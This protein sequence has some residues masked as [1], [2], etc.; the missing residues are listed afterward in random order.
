MYM[1]TYTYNG[2]KYKLVVADDQIAVRTRNAR[3]LSNAVQSEDGKKVLQNFK[4]T[5]RFEDSDVSVLKLKSSVKEKQ[6]KRDAARTTLKSEPELRFAGRVLLDEKGGEPVLY[7]ENL[8]IKFKPALTQ[9]Q[10][11]QIISAHQLKIKRKLPYAP[12]TYFVSTPEG[13]GLDVF[14]LAETMANLNEVEFCH[15]ELI[16]KKATKTIHP[17]QWHLRKTQI[18]GKLIDAHA[19]VEAAHTITR[20]EGIVIAVIDDGVDIDHPEFNIPGKVIAGRDVTLGINNPRPKWAS[21]NHGTSCA[22]VACASGIKV[23]GVAPAATLLPIRHASEL[24][25]VEEADAFF[26]AVENGADI[27]SCSWGPEDGD[28]RDPNDPLHFSEAGLPDITREAIKYAL[29]KGRQGKGCIICWAAGNG[30]E[31]MMLDGYSSNPDVIAVTACN[32]RGLR[33]VYSDFGRAAWCCFPSDDAEW[34]PYHQPKPLTK[35]IYTTDRK[36]SKGYASGDYA[37]DFGGTSSATPGV[38]GVAA[39]ILAINPALTYNEVRQIIKEACQKIDIAG[40]Q[41]DDNKHSI[42]YGYGRLDAW[43]AVQLAMASV[44]ASVRPSVRI[45]AAIVN[46]AGRHERGKESITLQNTGTTGI[47]M[48]QWSLK[49]ERNQ[50]EILPDLHLAAGTSQTLV[51]QHLRLSNAGGTIVLL[52]HQHQLMSRVTYTKAAAKKEATAIQFT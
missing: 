27:I 41:Y 47:M 50:S 46:P 35:G 1:Y 3:K 5:A 36:G 2:K 52:D 8:V 37:A 18:A 13:T 34:A 42:F 24:G 14:V 20:G 44:P 17:Q 32:D 49:N 39:L 22:G 4:L 7:T 23:S 33:S 10:C 21:D 40:G 51:L 19:N 28:W 45:T 38:A 48:K 15:P 12:N 9:E 30:R 29:E 25:S 11:E 16:R 31:D 26:W 43:T 6:Q